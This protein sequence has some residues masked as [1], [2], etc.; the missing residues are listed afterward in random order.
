M[1]PGAQLQIQVAA[2]ASSTSGAAS[3][4]AAA[5]APAPSVPIDESAEVLNPT[6]PEEPRKHQAT[7]PLPDALES[8]PVR[9]TDEKSEE[10]EPLF[11][12][13]EPESDPEPDQLLRGTVTLGEYSKSARLQMLESTAPDVCLQRFV[14]R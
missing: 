12:E 10:E 8:A 11:A 5:P 14:L 13:L 1:Q 7:T 9:V 2:A 3:A 4:P 6:Q